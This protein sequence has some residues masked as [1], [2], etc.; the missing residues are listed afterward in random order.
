MSVRKSLAISFATRYTEIIIQFLTSVVIARL[1]TP[2]EIGI[3][4]VA[5]VLVGLA[6][7]LRAFGVGT[8][9]IQEKELTPDR[10]RSAFGVSLIISWSIAVL[11]ATI[12]HPVSVF[13]HEPGVQSVM[14]VLAAN[15]FLIPFGSVTLSYLRR[16]MQFGVLYKASV[17]SAAVRSIAVI[18]L[19]WQDFSYMSMAWAAIAGV[20]T[21]IIVLAYYRPKELPYMPRFKEFGRILRFGSYMSAAT[22]MKELGTGAPDLVLGRAIS[23]DAVGLFGRASGLVQIFNQAVTTAILPVVLPHF[24]AKHREGQPVKD[25]YLRAMSYLTSLA[26]PFFVFV[27]VMAYPIVRILYGTQWDASVPIVHILC[28]DGGI[29]VGIAASAEI[30][31]ATGNVIKLV[32]FQI[33]YQGVRVVAVIAA[34]PFGLSAVALA[35]VA[36]TVFGTIV[37]YASLGKLIEVTLQD[38]FCA[39]LKSL[40]VAILCAVIPVVVTLRFDIGPNFLVIPLGVA[41][42]GFLVSWMISIVIL[43][44]PIREEFYMGLA[45]IKN[46]LT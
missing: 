14:L 45:H 21:N 31:V 18:I 1:L 38:Y 33:F 10:L 8:Y 34:V 28:I 27:G 13:Y 42:L 26:W 40:L 41:L 22:I 11:M 5:V 6:H 19:A 4:S 20:L 25:A 37:A 30:F 39:T 15:F 16:N 17:S 23:M 12:S 44:H 35:M 32:N 9:I 46:T 29:L 2:K 3:F 7:V 36:S 24:S 43:R